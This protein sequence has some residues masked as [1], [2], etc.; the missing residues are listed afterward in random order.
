MV[1]HRRV[2]RASTRSER[3][4]RGLESDHVQGHGGVQVHVHV[5]VQV[6]VDVVL[7]GLALG[8]F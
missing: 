2:K 4:R 8:L 5:D 3:H 6:N 1:E 7:A